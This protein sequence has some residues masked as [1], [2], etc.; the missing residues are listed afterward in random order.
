MHVVVRNAA[1]QIFLQRR[2]QNKRVQPGK[3]D[4]SVGGHVDPGESYEQA[5]RR[6]LYEELGIALDPMVAQEALRYRHDY[7]WRSDIETEHVRTFELTHEGPFALNAAE[8]DDGRFYDQDEL[9]HDIVHDDLTPN[10]V[11]EL[12]LLGLASKRST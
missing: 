11:H 9:Q 7:V 12:T 4:T 5:A 2:S 6:E 3:W 10:L 1:G 8:I